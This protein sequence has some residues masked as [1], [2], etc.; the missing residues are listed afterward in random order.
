M[1][2][3]GTRNWGRRTGG[4]LNV[5]EKL[6]LMGQGLMA[7][8]ASKR[9]PRALPE[10][11]VAVDVPQTPAVQMA[12]ALLTQTSQPWLCNHGHRTFL[13]ACALAARDGLQPDREVLYCA[14]LLHD[15]GLTAYAFPNE[16]ECFALKGSEAA[17]LALQNAGFSPARALV[18]AEAIALHLNLVVDAKHFGCEAALLRAGAGVDV[19]GQDLH[20][21]SMAFRTQTLRDF[22]RLDFKVQVSLAL[23]KQASR[24]PATRGGFLCRH[25]QLALRIQTVD[26]G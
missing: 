12:Q 8:M 18:A 16:G 23:L 20:R 7:V 3:F 14:S 21:I 4:Q 25:M 22:P 19:A 13:W 9:R 17:L 6:R 10:L 11:A 15:L 1:N 2:D 5:A 24:S 26:I